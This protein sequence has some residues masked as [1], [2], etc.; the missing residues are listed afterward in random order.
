MAHPCHP[1]WCDMWLELAFESH[2]LV[3]SPIS[4]FYNL[5]NSSTPL[6]A[7]VCVNKMRVSLWNN[8]E[9]EIKSSSTHFLC[10]STFYP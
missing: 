5:N 9:Q 6:G 10:I 7:Y 2:N 3:E 1:L 8:Q 4:S